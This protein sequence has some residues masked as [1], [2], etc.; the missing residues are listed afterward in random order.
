[1]EKAKPSPEKP[2][3][4]LDVDYIGTVPKEEPIGASGYMIIIFI[5]AVV[6]GCAIWIGYAYKYP[7]TAS[8]QMLIRVRVFLRIQYRRTGID[9][10][11][12]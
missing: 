1:M 7:H 12:R 8:G 9:R 5:I 6:V 4:H 3:K 2:A 11:F 10:C